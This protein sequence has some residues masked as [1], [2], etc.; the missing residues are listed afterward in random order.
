MGSSIEGVEVEV[1][2]TR[3]IKIV[4]QKTPEGGGKTVVHVVIKPGDL[5]TI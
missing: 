2:S 1:F 5:V 4:V 3:K